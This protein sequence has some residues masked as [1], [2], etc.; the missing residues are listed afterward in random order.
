MFWSL[1]FIN[2]WFS[3]E[4]LKNKIYSNN[5][6]K[7][8]ECLA[9]IWKFLNLTKTNGNISSNNV[10]FLFVVFWNMDIENKLNTLK[11]K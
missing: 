8:K 3:F 6:L 10:S 1:I 11:L 2:F 9:M 4:N 5:G 7:F